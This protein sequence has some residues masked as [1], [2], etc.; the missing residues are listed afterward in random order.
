MK[1]YEQYRPIVT[2]IAEVCSILGFVLSVIGLI[3]TVYTMF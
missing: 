1:K 3:L 2:L